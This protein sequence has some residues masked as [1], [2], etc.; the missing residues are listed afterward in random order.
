MITTITT[1]VLPEALTLEQA[2]AI[3]K[4]TAPHYQT[5]AGLVRK[6][7][8]LS[9]DGKTA[10]GIYLWRTRANAEALYT[11]GWRAFVREKYRTEPHVS[12]FNS[13]VV[14]DNA[15]HEIIADE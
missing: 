7:Y 15:T 9:E 11:D 12:Y 2:K 6:S 8:I 3:F 14:V 13:P 10:G 4:T 1:F 5:V